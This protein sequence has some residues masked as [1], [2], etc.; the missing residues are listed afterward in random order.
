MKRQWTPFKATSCIREFEKGVEE[1]RKLCGAKSRRKQI[2]RIGMDA[3]KAEKLYCKYGHKGSPFE[4]RKA[5]FRFL[6]ILKHNPGFDNTQWQTHADECD[7]MVWEEFWMCL[8]NFLQHANELD[9]HGRLNKHNHTT[10]FP[11]L[12]TLIGDCFLFGSTG[13]TINDVLFQPM[14]TRSTSCCC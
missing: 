12:V 13:G 3:Q 8:D 10:L 2:A 11:Y 9:F 7:R 6:Y 5:L 1:W 14:R 4:E